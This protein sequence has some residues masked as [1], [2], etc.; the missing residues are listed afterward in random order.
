MLLCK[1][2]LSLFSNPIP[3]LR[4]ICESLKILSIVWNKKGEI[5]RLIK[6]VNNTDEILR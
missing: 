1:L 2:R 5:M 3:K 6:N 4:K